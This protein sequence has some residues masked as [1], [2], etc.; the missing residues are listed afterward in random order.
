MKPGAVAKGYRPLSLARGIAL[1]GPFVLT[2]DGKTRA[3]E[4]E[5]INEHASLYPPVSS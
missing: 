5:A 3:R 4:L 1:Y 2:E